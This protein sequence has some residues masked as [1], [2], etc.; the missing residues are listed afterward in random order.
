MDEEIHHIVGLDDGI[1]IFRR[2]EALYLKAADDGQLHGS[3]RLALRDVIDV[4]AVD[5]SVVALTPNRLFILDMELH[6]RAE[7][8]I[9][10][11]VA[12]GTIGN[13]LAVR[14]GQGDQVR[15]YEIAGGRE[16]RAGPTIDISARAQLPGNEVH[17]IAKP[18]SFS[19]NNNYNY[20]FMVDRVRMAS[21]VAGSCR[22]HTCC[23]S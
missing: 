16:L 3:A 14:I 8:P 18:E 20:N 5:R 15:L 1:A 11:A 6:V 4:T 23:S 17:V 2:E 12:V 7:S 21:D 9:Q 10:D 19:R 13:R 22:C